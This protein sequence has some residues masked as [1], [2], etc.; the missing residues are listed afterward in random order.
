[1][2][3]V[4]FVE[5]L[6]LA[7]QRF[8]PCEEKRCHT[9]LGALGY[10]GHEGPCDCM[11]CCSACKKAAKSRDCQKAQQPSEVRDKTSSSSSTHDMGQRCT[12]GQNPHTSCASRAYL[13][14]VTA[15][16]WLPGLLSLW[17]WML[18]CLWWVMGQI[19][20]HS[21]CVSQEGMGGAGMVSNRDLWE[22]VLECSMYQILIIMVVARAVG[23][24][25]G[26]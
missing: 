25:L 14:M 7:Q 15:K 23:D 20:L 11:Q 26:P 13:C 12:S 19:V 18:G 5:A 1:M 24:R 16:Q 2:S 9:S 6:P 17:G 10:A 8:S 3:R 21:A 4:L 22:G